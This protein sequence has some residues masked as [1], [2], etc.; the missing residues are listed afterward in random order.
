MRNIFAMIVITIVLFTISMD[1]PFVTNIFIDLLIVIVYLMIV[2]RGALKLETDISEIEGEH[3]LREK[4]MAYF[5]PLI[6]LFFL[7]T[8]ISFGIITT[9][10]NIL[11]I[12]L[13]YGYI[14]V[15]IIRNKIIVTNNAITAE[16]LNGHSIT[17]K[18]VDIVKVDFDWIYNMIVFTDIKDT[19]IKLDISLYDFLLVITMM[20]ERLLKDD[21]EIAFRKLR[22]Y[23]M[24][25]L[26]KSNNIH[27]K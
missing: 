23:Y 25:F 1:F 2:A 14:V 27:L 6:F 4:K 11:V 8:S 9:V 16:Y 24:W 10:I 19:Q 5:A 7:S 18:W 13:L 17:M 3:T 12:V 22:N 21:Y 15:S 26:V 20:K